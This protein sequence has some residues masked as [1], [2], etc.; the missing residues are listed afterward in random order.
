[1]RTAWALL[2][3]G[4]LVTSG[5]F[6]HAASWSDVFAA[7]TGRFVFFGADGSL[8]R[9]P[10]NLA[11]RETL[12]RA[13]GGQHVVRARVSPDGERLAWL[14]RGDDQDTTRLWVDGAN[15]PRVRVR[16][17]ALEPEKYGRLHSEP[18]VPTIEDVDYA[19]VRLV[20]PGAFMRRLDCN[21]LEWTPDSRAV[22][23]GYNDGIAAVSA[24]G[25]AGFAV[26]KALPVHLDLLAPAPIYLVDA[27]VLRQHM[28]Y[29]NPVLPGQLAT[30]VT[31]P[32]EQ[33]GDLVEDQPVNTME[34]AH[35]DV[36]IS[37]SASAGTYL[38]YP[39]AHRWRVFRASDLTRSRVRAAS[40]GTVWWATGA[41]IHAIRTADPR[42]TDEA[43]ARGAVVWLDYDEPRHAV[44]WAGGR[45]VG[46][47][48]ED[49]GPVSVVLRTGTPIRA[50]IRSGA[51]RLVGLL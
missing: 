34:L 17:F 40:P 35:P 22:V 6:A 49:G 10:F 39:L 18:G 46:R 21:T 24:D 11:T 38:L 37:K 5:A 1:M 7:D 28:Q 50:A 2:V 25:G 41:S 3:A 20:Q 13:A 30:D 33:E 23:F 26:C 12:W 45:E 9:A 43:Q 31:G 42:P 8:L 47:R 36:M 16:Y 48:S 14:T 15:G 4:V 44:V 19:G 29:F 32:Y 51:S 27:I